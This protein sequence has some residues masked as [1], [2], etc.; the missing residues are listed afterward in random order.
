MRL[1]G[2]VNWM[3]SMGNI[4]QAWLGGAVTRNTEARGTRS[5]PPRVAAVTGLGIPTD[6]GFLKEIEPRAK[7]A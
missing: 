7:A 2:S 5:H 6:A 4:L 3:V 1:C